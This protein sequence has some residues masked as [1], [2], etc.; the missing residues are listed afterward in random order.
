MEYLDKGQLVTLIDKLDDLTNQNRIEWR[1]LGESEH[2]FATIAGR[3]G[4]T[5]SSRDEDD[6][7][8]FEFTIFRRE[9]TVKELQRASTVDGD[10]LQI[11]DLYNRVKRRVLN[12]ES[13]VDDIFNDL[14]ALDEY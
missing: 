8:P 9:K 1:K 4:Y 11:E 5:V 13:I 3:F 7:H 10:L 2:A 6:Y 12:L 14:R